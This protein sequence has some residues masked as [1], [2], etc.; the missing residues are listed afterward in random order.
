MP[1]D[2]VNILNAVCD[3]KSRFL[4]R[5][6]K[7]FQQAVIIVS[8]ALL[9]LA[10][11]AAYAG[12]SPRFKWKFATLAPKGVGYA[13]LIKHVLIPKLEEISHGDVEIKIY[14][15]GVM[16]DDLGIIRKMRFGHLNGAGLTGGGSI[17]LCPEMAVLSLPFLFNNYEEV[18]YVKEKMRPDFVRYME[19][20]GA[21][22]FA[23]IDQGFDQIYSTKWSF[24]QEKDFHSARF[25]TWYGL[26][27]EE[28]FKGLGKSP[29]PVSF[30]RV[31]PSLQDDLGD[32]VMGP[33]ILVVGSTM[34]TTF[35]YV[36]PVKIRYSPAACVIRMEDWKSLPNEYVDKYYDCVGEV[37][38]KF[39]EAIRRDE[40]IYMVAFKRYGLTVARTE[41]EAL[42]A[43]REQ[44]LPMWEKLAD[45]VYPKAVL[46]QVL[47]HLNEF[48]S[49]QDS[50]ETNENR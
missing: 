23:L 33:A 49:R 18:D 43:I 10:C 12:D 30:S 6:D 20:S 27:E 28:F 50:L 48:R 16:G 26:M 14:W 9:F 39:T 19:N 13:P 2:N 36:N 38:G 34:F 42:K 31:L 7:L 29:V 37:E 40:K 4:P 3:W 15:S 47:V 8:I 5:P 45:K 41:P 24:S 44:T 25:L 22:L 21:F 46:D 32:A 11:P 17:K 1:V 35:K